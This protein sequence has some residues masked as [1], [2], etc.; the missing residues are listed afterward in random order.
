MSR[1][2]HGTPPPRSD[3]E[4]HRLDVSDISGT[5]GA[6]RAFAAEFDLQDLAV[7]LAAVTG[8]TCVRGVLEGILEGVVLVAEI[9][10]DITETCRRCLEVR[11]RRVGVDVAEL[12]AVGGDDDETYRLEDSTL[13]LDQ[14]ARDALALE[15]PDAPLLC[16][17]DPDACPN[18]GQLREHGFADRDDD[19]PDPRW[20]P[21]A[22]FYADPEK[23]Q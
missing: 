18:L 2:E 12:F 15:L 8:P 13:D 1:A 3:A 20:A 22:A 16:V 4:S 9:S 6:T 11:T 23:E 14:C 10:A 17:G 19:E 21:L 5:P 7:P